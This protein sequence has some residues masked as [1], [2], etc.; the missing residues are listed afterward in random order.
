MF[1]GP[2]SRVADIRTLFSKLVQKIG[3]KEAVDPHTKEDALWRFIDFCTGRGML[4]LADLSE[5][6]TNVIDERDLALYF[7]NHLSS[8]KSFERLT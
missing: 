1:S 5:N 4:E 6:S 3:T 8:S 2:D 7:K